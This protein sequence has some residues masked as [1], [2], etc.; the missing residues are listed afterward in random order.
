MEING[1]RFTKHSNE[2]NMEPDGKSMDK[3]FLNVYRN[4]L[5]ESN[6]NSKLSLILN[7]F[8][9]IVINKFF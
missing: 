3:L 6:S 2:G 7:I 4:Y 9:K 1:T 5:I 8:Y